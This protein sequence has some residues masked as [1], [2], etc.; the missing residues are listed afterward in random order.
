M[1]RRSLSGAFAKHDFCRALVPKL[2]YPPLYLEYHWKETFVISMHGDDGQPWTVDVRL[3][4]HCHM[5]VWLR[6]FC[7]ASSSSSHARCRYY[8]SRTMI[9]MRC[10]SSEPLP[11]WHI[12]SNS[13]RS[14]QLVIEIVDHHHCVMGVDRLHLCVTT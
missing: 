10:H 8:S 7:C 2:K 3:L 9:A 4:F 1:R 12:S 6:Q 14:Q 13:H 5:H 11:S